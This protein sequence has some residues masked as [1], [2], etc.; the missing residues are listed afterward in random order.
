MK[1]T[2]DQDA[3]F[4][5]LI[6][7]AG[8]E[9]PKKDFHLSVVAKLSVTEKTPAYKPVISPL[10]WKLISGMVIGICIGVILFLPSGE[11]SNI[12]SNVIDSQFLSVL[13]VQWSLPKIS[14]PTHLHSLLID[15][16]IIGFAILAT[17]AAFLSS[18][19]M[20]YI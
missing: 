13:P 12:Y 4:K 6:A 19:K 2:M 7:D 18:R 10:A 9:T 20:K 11:Q 15:Q 1:N 14:L 16:A 3:Y 8:T 17:L 5:K